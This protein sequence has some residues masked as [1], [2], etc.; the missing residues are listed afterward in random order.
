MANQKLVNGKDT[1]TRIE[2]SWNYIVENNQYPTVTDFAKMSSVSYSTLCH[3]Y[4][5]WAEK[6]RNRRDSK[7][8]KRNTSPATL[9]K[10]EISSLK[11]AE[12]EIYQLKKE[13]ARLE[14]QTE[15]VK[16][17]KELEDKCNQLEFVNSNLLGGF[18]YLIDQLKIAGVNEEKIQRIWK[19]VESHVYPMKN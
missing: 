12:N 5:D 16:K 1:K 14:K 9:P 3:R 4:K 17:L 6:V 7:K 10:E 13:L 15:K 8:G 2:E 18:D 11:E 19:T